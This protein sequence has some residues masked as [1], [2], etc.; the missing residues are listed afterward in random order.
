MDNICER[1]V[2]LDGDCFKH[3]DVVPKCENCSFLS[4][5]LGLTLTEGK[6]IPSETRLN[7][8]LDKLAEEI[9]LDVKG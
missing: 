9:L 1:I 4:K 3:K 2:E 5:C 6:H 7:W 8:A